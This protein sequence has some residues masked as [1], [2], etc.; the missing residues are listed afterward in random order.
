M[1]QSEDLGKVYQE[2]YLKH[3]YKEVLMIMDT[4]HA[5]SLYDA[6]KAPNLFLVG[7]SNHDENAYSNQFDKDLSTNLNDKFSY[8]FHEFINGRLGKARF[9]KDT[10]LSQFPE[11]FSFDMLESHL[12]VKSTSIERKS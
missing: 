2:M 8:Y 9:T 6:V 1:L 4:C 11:I 10:R 3:M 5:M 7:S 12:E